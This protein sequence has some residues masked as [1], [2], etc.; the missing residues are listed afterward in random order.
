MVGKK[1][2]NEQK[3]SL[4]KILVVSPAKIDAVSNNQK[5]TLKNICKDNVNISCYVNDFDVDPFVVLFGARLSNYTNTKD[6]L[7]ILLGD[8]SR[9]GAVTFED[10]DFFVETLVGERKFV[11]ETI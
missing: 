10:V 7:N 4:N 9:S 2:V 11:C 3:R 1:D 5:A 6:W 8:L